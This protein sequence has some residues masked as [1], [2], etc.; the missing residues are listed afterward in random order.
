VADEK[1]PE[2][3][4]LAKL[5]ARKYNGSLEAASEARGRVVF[6]YSSPEQEPGAY[7]HQDYPQI[8]HAAD[9]TPSEVANKAE[10]DAWSAAQATAKSA[11]VAKAK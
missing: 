6:Q 11:E 5:A 3:N 2:L 7:Q 10:H 4:Y 9:G 1:V 8:V